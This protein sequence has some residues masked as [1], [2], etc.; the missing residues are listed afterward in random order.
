M[1]RTVANFLFLW[2]FLYSCDIFGNGSDIEYVNG[3][4]QDR[5]ISSAL[6]LLCE[7]AVDPQ[8]T[9]IFSL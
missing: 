4:V 5:S 8:Y 1:I 9:S 3:L 2:D 7:Q 6:A